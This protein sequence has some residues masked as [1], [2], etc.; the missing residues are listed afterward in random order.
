VKWPLLALALSSCVAGEASIVHEHSGHSTSLTALRG[1]VVVLNFWAEWCP[2]C[3]R[4][5]PVL[6]SLVQAAG[7]RVTLVPAYYQAKPLPGSRVN[8]W[9]AEQPSWFRERVCWVDLSL[10]RSHDLSRLPLTVVYGRDGA[11]MATFVGS[12]EDRTEAFAQALQNALDQ[13]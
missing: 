2:P 11:V 1:Q 7:P 3:I 12:V 8:A 10:R 4:E 5:L 9:L 6:A 13:P